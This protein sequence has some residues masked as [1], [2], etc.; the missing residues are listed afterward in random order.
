MS[1][2]RS[3]LIVLTNPTTPENS[4]EFN[5]W[6]DSVHVPEVIALVDGVVGATRFD[7]KEMPGSSGTAGLVRHTFA[8]LYEIESDDPES[9]VRRIGECA[10][11][12]AFN[13]SPTLDRADIPP[14]QI[15]ITPRGTT[16][17]DA[18]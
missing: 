13:M 4:D 5:E 1:A 12:G 8:A 18:S 10:A 15:L 14:L 11:A 7:A 16:P 17:V 2:E 9:V 6:Y 3:Q